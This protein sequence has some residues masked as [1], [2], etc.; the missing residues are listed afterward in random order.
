VF[1]KC[2]PSITYNFSRFLLCYDLPKDKAYFEGVFE[3]LI[4]V[5]ILVVVVDSYSTMFCYA[6]VLMQ[7]VFQK[8]TIKSL[9]NQRD[10]SAKNLVIR[11]CFFQL[12]FAETGHKH[13]HLSLIDPFNSPNAVA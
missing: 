6:H 13:T 12:K 1:H 4:S 9:V 10:I 3:Y 2:I 11:R 8:S 7:E 5:G